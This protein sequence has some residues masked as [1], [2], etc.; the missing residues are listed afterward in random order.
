MER[1]DVEAR[2]DPHGAVEPL[3]FTWQAQVWYVVST[4]R[5]WKD[6]S[7]EHIL[8]MLDGGAVFE[9][10]YHPLQERWSLGF[11]NEGMGFI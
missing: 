11:H 10:I 8:C 2:W 6:D 1:I 5:R 3:R 4:G 9:L 7:G